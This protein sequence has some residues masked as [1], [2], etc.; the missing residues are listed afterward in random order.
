M[1]KFTHLLVISVLIVWLAG[2]GCIGN[3]TSK[4]KEEGKDS[5]DADVGNNLPAEDLGVGLTQA[6]LNEVNCN[7]AGLENL[8]EDSSP[9]EEILVQEV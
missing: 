7:M 1:V 2:S 8:L 3:D 5:N 9:G 6:E 4:V